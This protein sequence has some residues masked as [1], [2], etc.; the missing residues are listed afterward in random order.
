[1]IARI[2]LATGLAA[3]LAV[4]AA[5]ATTVVNA[6]KTAHTLIITSKNGHHARL[7]LA[8]HRHGHVTCTA[9]SMLTLGKSSLACHAN[10]AKVFIKNGKLAL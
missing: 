6:D 9:G 7:A 3:G 10:T 1:M 8:G 5:N 2:L 4:S